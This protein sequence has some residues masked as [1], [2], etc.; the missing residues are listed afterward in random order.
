MEVFINRDYYALSNDQLSVFTGDSV[1]VIDDQ[2]RSS[3]ILVKEFFSGKQG[4]IP[5]DVC[6]TASERQAQLNARKNIRVHADETVTPRT[7]KNTTKTVC[8]LEA[9]PEIIPCQRYAY[10]SEDELAAKETKIEEE[11]EKSLNLTRILG[12]GLIGD[13]PF[14]TGTEIRLRIYKGSVASPIP[15]VYCTMGVKDTMTLKDLELAILPKFDCKSGSLELVHD[16]TGHILKLP[17]KDFTLSQVTQ[18]ARKVT[19]ILNEEANKEW[20]PARDHH[21]EALN[22]IRTVIYQTQ[23]HQTMPEVHHVLSK[24]KVV[25]NALSKSPSITI[26]VVV[27]CGHEESTKSIIV[28]RKDKLGAVI[29]HA[30]NIGCR[31]RNGQVMEA[32]ADWTVE[33]CHHR[34]LGESQEDCPIGAIDASWLE[35]VLHLPLLPEPQTSSSYS[36]VHTAASTAQGQS[37]F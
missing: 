14:G 15:M 33:E 32:D 19:M 16:E 2:A 18:I 29:R 24:Y 30:G 20:A 11:F 8:F 7:P 9:S 37:N 35:I 26:S 17:N 1:Q 31:L 27:R 23:M 5:A 34:L 4:F 36:H 6:E 10:E 28:D 21:A 22:K 25:L 13:K 3:W 12:K